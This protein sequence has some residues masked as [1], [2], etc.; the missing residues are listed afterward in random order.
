MPQQ[1]FAMLDAINQSSPTNFDALDQNMAFKSDASAMAYKDD[2]RLFVRFYSRSL[3]NLARS[4]EAGRAIH[5]DKVFINIK[6]PG[7]KNNDVNRVA[8]PEDFARFPEHYA[9]F[10]QGKEQVV[11]TPLNLLPFLTE[12]LVDDYRAMN[13][14][15][16]E[17]LAELG[18]GYVQKI[19]GAVE[20]KQRAQKFLE[21]LRG[22]DALRAEFEAKDRQRDEE[23][24][25]LKEQLRKQTELLEQL[26]KPE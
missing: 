6:I 19:M 17:Q 2:K 26:T 15:T 12:A 25:E 20:H 23:L 24:K 14:R 9:R 22:T 1:D 8:F 18:D 5:E 7:D 16:V 4:E 21:A 11:G 10:Q 3:L 13:V